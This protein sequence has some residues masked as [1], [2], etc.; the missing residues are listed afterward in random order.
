M[1]ITNSPSSIAEVN[2]AFMYASQV[3]YGTLGWSN[4]LNATVILDERL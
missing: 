1:Q 4:L 3:K 2:K